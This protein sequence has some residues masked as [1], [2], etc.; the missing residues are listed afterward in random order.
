MGIPSD[1]LNFTNFVY[2]C[3]LTEFQVNM[4]MEKYSPLYSTDFHG[5]KQEIKTYRIGDLIYDLGLNNFQIKKL[6]CFN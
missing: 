2:F 4:M 6:V 1:I 5:P 3:K